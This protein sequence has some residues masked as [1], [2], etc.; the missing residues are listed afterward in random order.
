VDRVGTDKLCEQL[1]CPIPDFRAAVTELVEGHVV[2]E[3]AVAK[4]VYLLL[5][6]E[7]RKDYREDLATAKRDDRFRALSRIHDRRSY[8]EDYPSWDEFLHHELAVE[9]PHD[10]WETEKRRVRIQQHMEELG[11]KLKIPLNKNMA[12]HLNRVRNDAD[13]FVSCVSEFQSLPQDRQI[14]KRLSEIVQRHLDRK[15]KLASLRQFVPDATEEE[16]AIL[17]PINATDHKWRNWDPEHTADLQ[18][19]VQASGRPVRDCLL[20]IAQEIKSLPGDAVLLGVARGRDLVPIVNDLMRLLGPWEREQK[21]KAEIEAWERQG[22]KLGIYP[23]PTQEA[24]EET[25]GEDEHDE[26]ATKDQEEA[27]DTG[28]GDRD[29]EDDG[30]EQEQGSTDLYDVGLTGDFGSRAG[31]E[32]FDGLSSEELASLLHNLA[33]AIEDGPAIQGQASLTVRP[34]VRREQSA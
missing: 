26:Q 24:A 9:N 13:L 17:A 31:R 22:R 21:N 23:P 4:T 29:E 1:G 14:A 20:E 16:L 28:Q 10:W 27:Q 32:G 7:E 18:G 12:Q 33:D 3:D 2:K 5:T 34:A 8:R 15:N 11:I 30:Q 25:K 19:R 6:D